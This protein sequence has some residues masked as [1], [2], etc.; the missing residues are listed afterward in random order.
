MIKIKINNRNWKV[1]FVKGTDKNL[2]A[3]DNEIVCGITNYGK[4]TIYINK[5]IEKDVMLDTIVH[6]LTHA[7]L[8]V[9]GFGQVENFTEENVCDVFGAFAIDLTKQAIEIYNQREI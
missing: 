7:Y 9:Y 6:E 1:R 2:C 5:E 3:E 8:F 4:A